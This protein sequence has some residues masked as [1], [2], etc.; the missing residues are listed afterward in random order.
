[1]TAGNADAAADAA[2]DAAPAG[3]SLVSPPPTGDIQVD[4][5]LQRLYDGAESG[6]LDDQAE[7]GEAAHRALQDRLADLGGD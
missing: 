4:T 7:A 6:S 2:D 3:P 5:A 1:V